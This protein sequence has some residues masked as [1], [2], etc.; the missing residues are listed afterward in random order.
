MI[1][2]NYAIFLFLGLALIL[3]SS[4]LYFDSNAEKYN[5]NQLLGKINPSKDSLFVKVD[6][7]FIGYEKS[8]YLL[9]PVYDA[10]TKMYKAASQEGIK[11]NLISGFRSFWHQKNIWEG[12]W[13]GRILVDGKKISTLNISDLEKAKRILKYS[14]M[15]GISRHHWGTDIDI[16]SLNN[17]DFEKGKNKIAYNWL[18]INA[19]KYGFCQAYTPFDSLRTKGFQEEKWHWSFIPISEK[20][21]IQYKNNI[22]YSDISGFKGSQTAEPLKVIDNYV[23]SINQ[24]CK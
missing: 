11:L 14:S 12:K 24:D 3:I 2:L 15:P 9:R 1:K 7:E 17:K 4:N 10:Y 20:L 21:I 16:I 19:K 18:L 8:I 13:N 6:K 22:N 23:L 5:K